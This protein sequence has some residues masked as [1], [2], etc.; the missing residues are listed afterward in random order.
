VVFDTE[1][2]EVNTSIGCCNPMGFGSALLLKYALK[3]SSVRLHGSRAYRLGHRHITSTTLI[4]LLIVATIFSFWRIAC[5][6]LPVESVSNRKLREPEALALLQELVQQGAASRPDVQTLLQ[7]NEPGTSP[8]ELSE[9]PKPVYPEISLSQHNL[10]PK[11]IHQTW[12]SDEDVNLMMG[13]RINT[14]VTQNPEYKHYFWTDE[15]ANDF[16]KESHPDIYNMYM[17]LPKK[18]CLDAGS[19]NDMV[20]THHVVRSTRPIFSVILCYTPLVEWYVVRA[21]D[22]A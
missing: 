6:P 13:N 21:V 7:L 10:I 17:A 12:K 1:N 4:L 16:V 20:F 3:S 18:V 22:F 5:S 11:F 8:Y 9:P 2:P 15:D 19:V 14:W